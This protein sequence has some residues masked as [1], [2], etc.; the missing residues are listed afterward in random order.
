MERGSSISYSA[1]ATASSSPARRAYSRAI[2]PARLDSSITMDEAR[3]NLASSPARR[4]TA[5]SAPVRPVRPM[6]SA[7]MARIRP[8]RSTI[9]PSRSVKVSLPS[10]RPISSG[11]LRRSCWKKN[12]ASS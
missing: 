1:R 7:A 12:A 11:V 9:E 6:S 4:T 8:A 5:A 3:S 2:V 10:P